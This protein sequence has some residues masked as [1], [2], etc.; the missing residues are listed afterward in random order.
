MP[1]LIVST[2]RLIPSS[3]ARKRFGQLLDDVNSNE[4][5]YYVILENGKVAGLLV[6]PAW[7]KKVEGT[8]D[9]NLEEIRKDWSRY[10]GDIAEAL[11]EI[12]HL[13]PKELPKLLK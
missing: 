2:D 3:E 1:G 5:A 9:F 11:E 8:E 7:L 13:D 12:D 6:H 4:S 10:S